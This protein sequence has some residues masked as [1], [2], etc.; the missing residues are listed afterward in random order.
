M[1]EVENAEKIQEGQVAPAPET[2]VTQTETTPNPVAGPAPVQAEDKKTA[3]FIRLRQENR[4]LK[5]KMAQTP[6]PSPT[7]TPTETQEPVNQTVVP[8][9]AA[10][11]PHKVEVDIEAESAKAIENLAKEA[12]VMSVPG[13]IVDIIEMVDTDPRLARLHNID[14][15]LA[16]REAKGLWASKAGISTPPPV[17]AP[18]KVSGGITSVPSD[19]DA[20]YAKL[21]NLTPG[22]KEYTDLVRKLDAAIKK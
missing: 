12:D 21:E 15:V 22:T 8:E 19:L 10:P 11:T 17:P 13:A 9:Q 3:A 18:T 5:R 4:E 6:T 16:F 7:P 1:P 20:L 14:P 2:P